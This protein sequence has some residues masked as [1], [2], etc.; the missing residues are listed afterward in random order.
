[1]S[2][3]RTFPTPQN[4]HHFTGFMALGQTLPLPCLPPYKLISSCFHDIS[5]NWNRGGEAL[6]F[7]KST[8]PWPHWSS[9]LYLCLFD[10]DSNHLLP[11]LDDLYQFVT[12][13]HKFCLM[14]SS[15]HLPKKSRILHNDC[16]LC[17]PQALKGSDW[18]MHNF[19]HTSLI[20][21]T[22]RRRVEMMILMMQ[23]HWSTTDR[24]LSGLW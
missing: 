2:R 19:F 12:F 6:T 9:V 21:S 11:L 13:F 20:R 5:S 15:I 4:C 24:K 7:V 22:P 18:H 10:F 8:L 14:H 3:Y 17:P 23:G 16:C 1:M